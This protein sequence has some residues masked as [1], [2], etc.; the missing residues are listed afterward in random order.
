V[1]LMPGCPARVLLPLLVLFYNMFEQI[2]NQSVNQSIKTIHG[3]K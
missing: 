3:A 1:H 2:N